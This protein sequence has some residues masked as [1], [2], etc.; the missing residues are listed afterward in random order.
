MTI[1]MPMNSRLIPAWEDTPANRITIGR[2]FVGIAGINASYWLFDLP[3]LALASLVVAAF[4]DAVDGYVARATKCS[5]LGAFLDPVAD[6]GIHLSALFAAMDY[7]QFSPWIVVP[8]TV[9]ISYDLAVMVARTL[10][11]AIRT[12]G[13]AKWKQ[14]ILFSAVTTLLTGI[15][16]QENR[17]IQEVFTAGS[18]SL[19]IVGTGLLWLSAM[20]SLWSAWVYFRAHTG[21]LVRVARWILHYIPIKP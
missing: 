6:K 15:A 3:A 1:P 10:T 16:F 5:E 8:A 14:A 13:T 11:N 19:E 7:M 17:D 21:A 4:L 18:F 20:W 9:I 2:L 12:S